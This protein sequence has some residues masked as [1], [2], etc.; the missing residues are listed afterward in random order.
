MANW[1]GYRAIKSEAQDK[2]WPV[3]YKGDITTHDRQVLAKKTAPERFVWVLRECGTEL[4]RYGQPGALMW[5]KAV[6]KYH[7]TARWYTYNGSLQPTTAADAL[8][9]LGQ[10]LIGLPICSRKHGH[11]IATVCAVDISGQRTQVAYNPGS[12]MRWLQLDTDKGT[13][14]M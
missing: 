10:S 12:F 13:I 3:I 2:G 6:A 9:E 11:Q 4:L 14:I 5:A 8:T 7:P 1:Q